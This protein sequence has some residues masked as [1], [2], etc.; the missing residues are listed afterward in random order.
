[1]APDMEKESWDGIPRVVHILSISESGCARAVE[2][3]ERAGKRI[4][5]KVSIDPRVF[6]GWSFDLGLRQPLDGSAAVIVLSQDC[7]DNDLF[8]R[9]VHA[10]VERGAACDD[11]RVYLVLDD[12]TPEQFHELV[13]IGQP[14]ITYL[15]ENIQIIT[16]LQGNADPTTGLT[17]D[18]V[19]PSL[20]DY[21]SKLR[22]VQSRASWRRLKSDTSILVSR[23]ALAIQLVSSII[24]SC[25]WTLM[26]MDW[27]SRC[28]ID[29]G[30]QREAISL[31]AG[32]LHFW[33]S[34]FPA[35]FVLRGFTA[36]AV[37]ARDSE[38]VVP[39]FMLCFAVS[40]AALKMAQDTGAGNPWMI[41][42]IAVGAFVDGARRA[43][44]QAQKLRHGLEPR[45]ATPEI[46]GLAT[47]LAGVGTANIF[48]LPI[49]PDISQSIVISYA[50]ASKWSYTLATELFLALEKAQAQVFLDRIRIPVGANWRR[51]LR[52]EIGGANTFICI[53]DQ[54]AIKRPWVAAEFYNA[55]RGQALTGSP[56]VIVLESP[57]LNIED[58]LPIFGQALVADTAEGTKMHVLR[59][60]RV[61]N[62][63]VEVLSHEMKPA[64]FQPPSVIPQSIAIL[65]EAVLR[66]ITI[67]C[68]FAAMVGLLAWVG[69]IVEMWNDMP[70]FRW[71]PLQAATA[72]FLLIAYLA[73]CGCRLT[74]VS[75]Y[76]LRHDDPGS[77]AVTQGFGAIGL[78]LLCALWFR[79]F[80]PLIEGWASVAVA[81]G[82][83]RAGSF[84]NYSVLG[85][86]TLTR[87]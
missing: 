4:G 26:K 3:V 53:L 32:I 11:F 17:E 27:A 34:M 39:K 23:V 67:L 43:G 76:Q 70:I 10:V 7:A 87:T 66:P 1:M 79:A 52:Y 9:A 25:G 49:W 38:W 74:V 82:W 65:L 63:T 31:S 58:A 18:A 21:L 2:M 71:L 86:R 35:Y 77:L 36:P 13:G 15:L 56:R 47:N 80:P 60:V 44:I 20:A 41:L 5:R 81:F 12:L 59:R 69:W 50:R 54:L 85:D 48:R 42:G 45:Y 29:L 64:G 68:A 14:L 37:A 8:M 30:I 84:F 24:L 28:G 19:E 22:D 51:E 75:K 62:R 46:A 33:A 57:S 55:I 72:L 6:G 40:F 83:W 78:I 16:G 61:S 73:G